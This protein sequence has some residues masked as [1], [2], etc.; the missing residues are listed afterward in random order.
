MSE[1]NGNQM[2]LDD[3]EQKSRLKKRNTLP[4]LVAESLS[5]AKLLRQNATS[6]TW[7]TL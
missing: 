1:D 2:S 3:F 4:P 5:N 6:H 7:A